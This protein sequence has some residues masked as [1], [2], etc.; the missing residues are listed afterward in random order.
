M[1][2]AD[3]FQAVASAVSIV[4]CSVRLAKFIKNISDDARDIHDWL[5][6][7]K[8]SMDTL[9]NVL[10]FVQKVVNG[11]NMNHVDD[12]P[13]E[14]IYT[15]VRS[16]QDLAAKILEKLPSEPDDGIFSKME[17]VLRKLMN[18]RVIKDYEYAIQKQTST[19]Q[20]VIMTLSL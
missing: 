11:P 12:G 18:D 4:D 15:I 17:S 2:G 5:A 20:T 3:V 10:E 14:W 16:S 1:T 8:Y 13:V 7:M 9:Q 19:L 6:Q